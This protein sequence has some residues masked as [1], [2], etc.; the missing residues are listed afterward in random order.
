[1]DFQKY[2]QNKLNKI[3]FKIKN[4]N[5]KIYKTK[6]YYNYHLFLLNKYKA[7]YTRILKS[8]NNN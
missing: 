7:K 4:I 2:F 5:P 6:N 8:L 3:N 1:M